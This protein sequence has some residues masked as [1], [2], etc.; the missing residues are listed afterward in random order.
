MDFVDI[1]ILGYIFMSLKQKI[2]HG[3]DVRLHFKKAAGGSVVHA[4]LLVH[5]QIISFLGVALN[6][7]V[8]KK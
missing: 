1:F 3:V 8:H 7:W 2:R 6:V 4:W 5:F